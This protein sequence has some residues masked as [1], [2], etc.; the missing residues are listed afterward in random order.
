MYYKGRQT[1]LQQIGDELEGTIRWD[2]SSSGF[3]RVRITPHL[4]RVSNDSHLWSDRYDR[5]I[6]DIFTVQS[7][8]AEQVL[9]RLQTVLLEPE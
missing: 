3:G 4:I 6:E 2:R 1:S 9:A 8:I 5:V 7:E